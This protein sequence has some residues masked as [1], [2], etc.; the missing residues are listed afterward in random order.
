MS[1]GP[2]MNLAG[3]DAAGDT[4]PADRQADRPPGHEMDNQA[5]L[6]LLAVSHGYKRTHCLRF[7]QFQIAD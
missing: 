4:W 6:A 3:H 1:P 7:E 5:R 2:D